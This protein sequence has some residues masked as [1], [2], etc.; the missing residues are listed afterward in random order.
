[1]SQHVL[2]EVEKY[3]QKLQLFNLAT[4]VGLYATIQMMEPANIEVKRQVFPS[5]K[6]L[7]NCLRMSV[8]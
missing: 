4:L 2:N 3:K 7:R 6:P 5:H 1:M 8:Q